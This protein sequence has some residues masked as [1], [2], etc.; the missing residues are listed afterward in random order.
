[1]NSNF[2]RYCIGSVIL[3]GLAFFAF[4]WQVREGDVAIRV[5]LGRP[6]DV[7]TDAGLHWRLPPPSTASCSSTDATACCEPATPRCSHA[8]RRTS[9]C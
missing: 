7:V 4:T 9:S 3:L 6:A 1:M 5:R 2:I 8:T